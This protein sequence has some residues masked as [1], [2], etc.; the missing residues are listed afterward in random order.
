MPTTLTRELLLDKGKPR[1][2]FVDVPHL[3][4]V[5]IRSVS[6][7]RQSQRDSTFYDDEGRPREDIYSK[8]R[9]FAFVDQLMVD[10]STPMFSE[11]DIPEILEM[12][13]AIVRPLYQAIKDFNNDGAEAKNG[14]PVESAGS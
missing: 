2:A 9:A 6:E 3:G 13:V 4:T 14:E 7:L 10:E 12:D 1:F 5:G 11:S 8:T